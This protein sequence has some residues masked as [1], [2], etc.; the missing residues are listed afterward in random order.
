MGK[1][2]KDKDGNIIG[3]DNNEPITFPIK[4]ECGSCTECCRWLIGNV[5]GKEYYPGRPCHFV[6]D[7]GCSIYENR[8]EV[9]CKAFYCEWIQNLDFP[10]WMKPTNSKVILRFLS[11]GKDSKNIFLEA[12]E[13]GEKIDPNALNFLFS[14]H[15]RTNIPIKIQIDGGWNFYGPI[16]FLN[17]FNCLPQ[18]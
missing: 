11:W 14:Y 1:I 2:F 4:R 7:G 8:P 10:E 6:G 17:Y 3:Y 12:R 15:M 18:T 16:E 9:P 13:C 5:Y